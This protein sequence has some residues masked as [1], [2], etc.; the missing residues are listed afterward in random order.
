MCQTFRYPHDHRNSNI[1][2]WR[3]AAD[4]LI[5]LWDAF[6]GDIIRTLDGH[7]EGIS[8]IAWSPDGE[9]LASASDDKTIIIWSLELVGTSAQG[10]VTP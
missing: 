3:K 9:Y 5:K 7:K 6:T 10:N 1:T 4:R 2:D 8:D